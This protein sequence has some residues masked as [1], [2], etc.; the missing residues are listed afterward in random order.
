MGFG[1]DA[2]ERYLGFGERSNAVAQE[3]VVENYVA[4]GPYQSQEYPLI[5]LFVPPWGIRE[6][7]DSTYFP[8]PWL[9]SSDG[10]GVLVDSPETSYFRLRSEA[11]DAWT[12]EVAAA[13]DGE[14]GAE[15]AP[16][17]DRISLSFFAGPEPADVVE[18]MSRSVGRQ[19]TPQANWVYGPW[20][21]TGRRRAGGARASSPGTTFRSPSSRRS[22][23]TS[24]AATRARTASA[25]A[26]PRRTRR[27]SPITTYFNPMVCQ[28]YAAAYDPAAASG[29]LTRNR[30]GEPYVYR[31]GADPT[32]FSSS[33]STT[34]SAQA[35]A[36]PTR[37]ARRGGGRRLRRLDGGL[38][39][40]HA[41]RL[42]LRARDRRH[43]RP[44]P[45]RHPLPLRRL[46]RGQA[47]NPPVVRFQ[48]SGWTGRR[49]VRAGGLGRRPDHLARLRRPALRG[50]PGAHD[51][52]LRDQRL[53]IG[54]RRLL[55]DRRQ[56]AQRP[57]CSLAGSSS[58]PSRA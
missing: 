25:S 45:L 5:N 11:A 26:P 27:A 13:P 35:G 51:R 54:H 3:G 22:P 4:D 46:R 33:A 18:R 58:A 49:D 14:T 52:P 9:L 29:A 56:L 23:T 43:P 31:Y 32:T 36:T 53:G 2:A 15:G 30:L 44:Q 57:S 28:N 41:A 55:R 50:H 10:Y 40:V 21:Q 7:D 12:V 38:R 34:S 6:R 1:A 16:P 48:R 19:P 39:R 24:R 37:A 42:G 17:P 8:I 20:Y 47:A